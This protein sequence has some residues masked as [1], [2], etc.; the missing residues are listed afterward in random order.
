MVHCLTKPALFPSQNGKILPGEDSHVMFLVNVIV[1]VVIRCRRCRRL[2]SSVVVVVIIRRRRCRH[3]LLF[4]VS[5][6]L[7]LSP[8]VPFTWLMGLND[9]TLLL[10]NI[11]AVCCVCHFFCSPLYTSKLCTIFVLNTNVTYCEL[12]LQFT[13]VWFGIQK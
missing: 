2:P 5:V 13:V 7:H 10:L 4:V 1:A 11:T 9:W 8:V 12:E 3:Q 6:V